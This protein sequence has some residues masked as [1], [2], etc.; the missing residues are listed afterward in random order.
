MEDVSGSSVLPQVLLISRWPKCGR[1][2]RGAESA[3]L[4]VSLDHAGAICSKGRIHMFFSQHRDRNSEIILNNSRKIK[5][6]MSKL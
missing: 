3:E 2:V 1:N 4:L 5:L 6:K